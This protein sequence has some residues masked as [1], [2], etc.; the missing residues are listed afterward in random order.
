MKPPLARALDLLEALLDA[1]PQAG[2]TAWDLDIDRELLACVV[3]DAEGLLYEQ[4]R[5]I[6]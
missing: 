1:T 3:Q 5:R 6:P 2:P 4:G